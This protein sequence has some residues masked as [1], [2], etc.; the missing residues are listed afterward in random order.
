[1][2]ILIIDDDAGVRTALVRMLR[3]FA[4]TAEATVEAGLERWAATPFDLVLCDV[5]MP[6]GGALALHE[7]VAARWPDRLARLVFISG[8][9]LNARQLA[10]LR[11]ASPILLRKPF[12][13]EEVVALLAGRDEPPAGDAL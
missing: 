8:A 3:R 9:L 4:V 11:D 6:D 10:R 2:R 12:G 7:M 5:D 13:V 1:M